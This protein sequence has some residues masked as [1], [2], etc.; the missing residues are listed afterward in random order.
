MKLVLQSKVIHLA[1]AL[2]A[3][4]VPLVLLLEPLTL[5]MYTGSVLFSTSIAAVLAYW[6]VVRYTMHTRTH[7]IDRTDVLSIGIVLLFT[8]TAFREVYVTFWREFFPLRATRLD[9]Y[10][11][12]L[13]FV[14][15]IAIVA[16]IMSLCARRITY[17]P[18]A[19]R[20]IPGW[21]AAIMSVSLGIAIGTAMVI[22]F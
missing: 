13:S 15:Y 16:A 8:A 22:Y 7:K 4:F 18:H 12:P 21:P 3:F 14:R 11:Y 20:R 10:F 2:L 6:P 19:F 17:G 5:Y 1:V 9:E